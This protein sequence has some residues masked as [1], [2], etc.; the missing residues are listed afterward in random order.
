[1]RKNPIK[2]ENIDIGLNDNEFILG[3]EIIRK[4]NDKKNRNIILKL[5]IFFQMKIMKMVIFSFINQ[6]F[7]NF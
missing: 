1:M 5:L 2:E 6:I 7:H 3:L 4:I